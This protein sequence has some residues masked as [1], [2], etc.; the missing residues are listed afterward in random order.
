MEMYCRGQGSSAFQS[1]REV[2]EA[3]L[4]Q[5]GGKINDYRWFNMS[6]GGWCWWWPYLGCIDNS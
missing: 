5:R 3:A 1:R 2:G 6:Q 4:G